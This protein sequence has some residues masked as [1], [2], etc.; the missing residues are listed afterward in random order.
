[1]ASCLRSGSRSGAPTRQ[2]QANVCIS[3]RVFERRRR[4]RARKRAATAR[5][6]PGTRRRPA[7]EAEGAAAPPAS[8]AALLSTPAPGR[9]GTCHSLPWAGA[10]AGAGWRHSIGASCI[11][12]PLP[13]TWTGTARAARQHA[14]RRR[15]TP[16]PQT[17]CGTPRG[18]PFRCARGGALRGCIF[19]T[20]RSEQA[21]RQASHD[22]L[23]PEPTPQAK[24]TRKVRGSE[25]PP[26][27]TSQ[28]ARRTVADA[29][30][31]VGRA[32]HLRRQC[33]RAAWVPTDG[34]GC[35]SVQHARRRC[36]PPRVRPLHAPKGAVGAACAHALPPRTRT[37]QHHAN[38][39]MRQ[40][41]R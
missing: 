7:C 14:L 2:R 5:K 9:R 4:P 38:S 20:L 32:R 28:V 11:S 30:A 37:L 10:A 33:A 26:P 22:A 21:S 8:G 15:L 19:R 36:V 12:T 25:L 40:R 34:R 35:R 39:P 3:L 1:M 27:H 16:L 17:C 23:A 31:R 13:W 18:R 29:L 6:G 24:R 41:S